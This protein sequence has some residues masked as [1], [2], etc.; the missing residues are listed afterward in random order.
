MVL[1]HPIINKFLKIFRQ[2]KDTNKRGTFLF[3]EDIS[4]IGSY[5]LHAPIINFHIKRIVSY[6]YRMF[7]FYFKP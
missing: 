4:W 6:L 2:I 1:L 5:C 3:L 7:F